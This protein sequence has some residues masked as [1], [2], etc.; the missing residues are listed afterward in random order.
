M[1]GKRLVALEKVSK[2]YTIAGGKEFWALRD[3]SLEVYDRE[4]LA[5]M[6]PSGHGKTTLMNMMGL[7]DKPTSGRVIVDDV[8]TA[9]LD[10]AELSRL[11]NEKLGFVF[12]QYNLIN[13][14]SVL[15]NIEIPLVLRG[16]PRDQRLGMAQKALELAAGDKSWLNKRPSQLSGGEQQRVA[17]TRA[18]VGDPQIILADEPTGNLDSASAKSIIHTFLGLNAAGKTII[19]VTHNPEVASASR[20]ILY[21]KDGRIT[22]EE[23]QGR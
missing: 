7:L 12:Q 6:G 4:L 19:M 2:V 23:T 11:R 5:I 9:R 3:V 13:R 17:I 21:I 22:G 10:D 8:D 14:M 16:I 1:N 20:R 15:E 18:I